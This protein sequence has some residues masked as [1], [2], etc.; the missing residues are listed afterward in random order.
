MGVPASSIN[1]AVGCMQALA[2]AYEA[3]TYWMLY[4]SLEPKF[5]YLRSD[6]GFVALQQRLNL[7]D[8][9]AAPRQ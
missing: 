1:A 7:P 6:P 5:D 3:R 4:L 2:K 8:R 9:A